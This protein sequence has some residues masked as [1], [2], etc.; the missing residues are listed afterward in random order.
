MRFMS[1]TERGERAGAATSM[2]IAIVMVACNKDPS[3]AQ[4]GSTT[5]VASGSAVATGPGG[6]QALPPCSIVSIPEVES[7]LGVQGLQGP[8]VGGEWPVR[9]CNF[10]RAPLN[11]P[12]VTVRFEVGRDAA[13]FATTRKHHAEHGQPTKSFGIRASRATALHRGTAAHRAP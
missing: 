7:T 10:T 1:T 3:P 4:A 6:Q 9:A 2:L 5:T 11:L 8:E 12:A 13:D